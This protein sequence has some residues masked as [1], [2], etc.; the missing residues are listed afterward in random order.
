M[1]SS[2]RILRYLSGQSL[3]CWLAFGAAGVGPVLGATA[4]SSA[5][6]SSAPAVVKEFIPRIEP[7][8]RVFTGRLSVRVTS[9]VAD[10]EV[11]FT[12][13]GSDPTLSSPAGSGAFSIVRT[14]LVR[15]R[16]YRQGRPIGPATAQAYA[17]VSAELERY[18]GNLPLVVV[19]VHGQEIQHETKRMASL[20]FLDATNG[21]ASFSVPGQA[22]RAE[23]WWRGKSSLRYLKRSLGVKTRD[24]LGKARSVSLLGF[25]AD[26]DWVLY[27]PYPDKTLIRDVLAYELS[28]QM[29]H[30]AS[31]TRFV[32][33]FIN[34]GTGRLT[35]DHYMGVYVL[36]EK[37]KRAPQRV[38]VQKLGTNDNAEPLITGG[39]I[40]KKDHGDTYGEVEP[41]VEGRPFYGGGGGPSSGNR[42]GYPT[43][44]G[45]FPADPAGFL[46]TLGGERAQ[47]LGRSRGR[48]PRIPGD[49]VFP[50][51]GR[52]GQ[53]IEREVILQDGRPVIVER[54]F[55]PD[56]RANEFR[57]GFTPG[58]GFQPVAEESFV[59]SHGQEFYYVE[60]K[61]DEI[62]RAQRQWLRN[63]L[64]EFEQVLAGPGFSDPKR[65]YAAYLDADSF[66]DYHLLVE[67]TK[68]IDGFRFS[69][70]FQKDRGGRIRAEPVWDWNLSFGNANGKQGWM[71]EHWYWPQLDD[72]QY[73]YYRRLF[74]D[75]DFGQRYVD[76]WGY[77]KETVF[78]LSNVLARI[79]HHVA[80]IGEARIRNFARWPILG[81]AIWPNYYVGETYDDE[82]RYLKEWTRKRLAW[83][84]AQFTAEPQIR[85]AK[86]GGPGGVV[87]TA[88]RGEIYYTRDGSDPRA[89]GGRPA[90]G[91]LR[92]AGANP[93]SAPKGTTLKARAVYDGRWSPP[94][95]AKF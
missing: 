65:G 70:Y 13:D 54:Q 9:P 52:G 42:Y 81:R 44:P 26:S 7:G 77:L 20:F 37:I 34:E 28:R 64:N 63:H 69:T 66:I 88:A 39:Y 59:T 32:E 30:Y 29:G 14:T 19:N 12:V 90:A 23:V 48:M 80:T 33:V 22:V 84:E 40:F 75:P 83:I 51:E 18:S 10:A 71:A 61:E 62:T 1:K 5:A 41:T 76:R 58:R 89:S 38:N 2:F 16:L 21:A 24:D 4:V 73:P 94:V 11:R 91:A 53:R 6:P 35:M 79:D 85:P 74:E 36:E 3:A 67:V 25:P 92:V 43:G 60:P 31:R 68:N 86:G 27:A 82:V 78:S 57:R 45:G 17:A 8:G 72:G 95:Q 87:L 49:G 93:V 55:G 46:P 56:G 47:E 15:A 50:P